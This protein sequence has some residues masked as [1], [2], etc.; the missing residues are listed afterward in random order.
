[1]SGPIHHTFAPLGDKR[2]RMLALRLS[3]A[4][5]AYR[6]GPHAQALRI[7]L[8]KTFAGRATLFAT[9]REAL[10]A[11][12]RTRGWSP[13]DEVI[14][15]GY[16]CTVVPNA[17]RGA[18]LAP[19]YADIDPQ[20]LSFDLTNVERRITPKTRAI[21]CQHTFGIPGPLK[22]LRALCDR[23]NLLLIE[24]CAHVLPDE[25]GPMEIGRFGDAMLLSFGRD[26]A[27]SG[28]TGGAVI[29]RNDRLHFS[30]REQEKAA[31]ELPW[32]RIA[33]YLEYPQIYALARFLY[34]FGLGKLFLKV[35]S[36]LRLLVPILSTA[37]KRGNPSST[38]YALPDVCAALALDQ[39]R[40]LKDLND[41][42]RT[43][44][45]YYHT[46]AQKRG[47]TG[48]LNIDPSWPLQK[49]PLFTKNAEGIRQKLKKHNIH[50]HDGWTGCVLLPSSVDPADFGYRDGDDPKAEMVGQQILSLPTH[51]TMTLEQAKTLIEVLDPLLP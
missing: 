46:E 7:L 31:K 5:W 20:T 3:Y 6:R 17:V 19:V 41:H 51:P 18:G 16:T 23:H 30:L 38:L 4:P 8:E 27:V 34:R 14:V 47:W 48:L 32:P 25:T 44:T 43:L 39:L 37:E 22:E 24:D 9:G 11:L 28:V 13:G 2:Q 10:L 15:Q 26:K 45:A 12:L 33:L 42:R 21:L 35:V 49:Y 29:A 1:M 36:T 40:R 50:L